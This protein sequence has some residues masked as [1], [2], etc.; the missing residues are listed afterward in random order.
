MRKYK[1]KARKAITGTSLGREEL[2]EYKQLL[3]DLIERYEES[4]RRTEESSGDKKVQS[5]EDK[6]NAMDMRQ[7]A[8]ESYGKT[9]KR[10]NL[11]GEDDTSK[12]RKSR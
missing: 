4:E 8:M 2:T 7:K 5:Q 6:N 1:S 9:R 12:E 10:K 11:E 3:E